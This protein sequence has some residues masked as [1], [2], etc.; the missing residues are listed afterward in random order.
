MTK[1]EKTMTKT[2][3]NIINPNPNPGPHTDMSEI[4]DQ[5]SNSINYKKAI[6][7]SSK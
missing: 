1:K 2:E 4:V 3:K 5:K 7:K 6:G